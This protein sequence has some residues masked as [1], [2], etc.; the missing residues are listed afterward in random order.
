VADRGWRQITAGSIAVFAVGLAVALSDPVARAP[1]WSRQ[2]DSPLARSEVGAARIG[3]RIYVVGGFQEPARTVDSVARFDIS[4]DRW[5]LVA[6]MPVALN[7]PGVAAAKGR[8]YVAGG[9]AIVGGQ[10]QP[11]DVLAV[12]SPKRDRWRRLASMPTAR[13]ALALVHVGGRLYAIGGAGRGDETLTRV[14]V[15]DIETDKWRRGPPL[16]VGRNHLA[17]V[18]LDG[19]VYAL[20]G[21]LGDGSNLRVVHVLDEG[22]SRWRSGEPLRIARSGFAAVTSAGRIIAFGGE[23]FATAPAT[24][25][26]SVERFDPDGGRWTALPPMPTPR[27]GLGGAAYE[28]RVYALEGG[29]EPGL[30]FSSVVEVLDLR[31]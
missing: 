27:H 10:A 1:E 13:G 2:A 9:N 21:R 31:G 4:D 26:G 23:Q 3:D 11:S 30:A 14:E 29:P 16:P 12:Y 20:G 19:D 17:A 28:G 5:R 8:L 24:T 25:I 15:Y 18:A 7:H 22:A 6:P